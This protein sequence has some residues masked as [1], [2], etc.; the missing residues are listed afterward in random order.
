MIS[1]STILSHNENKIYLLHDKHQQ[2]SNDLKTAVIKTLAN[3][4]VYQITKINLQISV[5]YLF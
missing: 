1:Q 4:Q 2:P 3:K 5:F